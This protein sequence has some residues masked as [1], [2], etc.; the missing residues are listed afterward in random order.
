MEGVVTAVEPEEVRVYWLAS[1]R[2][3]R[4]ALPRLALSSH[5]PYTAQAFALYGGGGACAMVRGTCAGPMR[6]Q[7]TL[8]DAEPP[9]EF[10]SGDALRQLQALTHFDFMTWQ[11]RAREGRRSPLAPGKR[12][13]KI[14][15]PG[16]L[17]ALLPSSLA[18]RR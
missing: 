8:E 10:L 18:V 2:A 15:P 11:A 17:A 14:A 12:F 5:A 6:L 4:L 16:H 1:G 13:S 9:P 3:R 7:A